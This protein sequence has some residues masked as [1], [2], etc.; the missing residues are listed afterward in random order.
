M[1]IKW[2]VQYKCGCSV[3]PLYRHEILEYCGT[4]GSDIQCK[5]KFRAHDE[6]TNPTDQF[7]TRW[8]RWLGNKTRRDKPAWVTLL[9]CNWLGWVE[10]VYGQCDLDYHPVDLLSVTRES[11]KALW[12]NAI[13][14]ADMPML[15][16]LDGIYAA[17]KF[18]LKYH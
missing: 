6:T 11:L 2:I 4:H 18:D 1:K 7:R 17:E 3:G 15:D 5:Y 12:L 16:K 9:D 10:Y 13:N 8:R 14:H